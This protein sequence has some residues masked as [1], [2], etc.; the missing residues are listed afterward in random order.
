MKLFEIM[1]EINSVAPLTADRVEFLRRALREIEVEKTED[2]LYLANLDERHYA[3]DI[4][5]LKH[6]AQ[7]CRDF[8]RSPRLRI[9]EGAL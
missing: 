3:E 9:A 4:R 7:I 6:A 5:H 2:F 1:A 8:Q